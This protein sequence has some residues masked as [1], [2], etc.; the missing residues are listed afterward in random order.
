ML[1]VEVEYLMGRIMAS[2]YNDRSRPEYPPHPSRLFSAM[3]A[4]YEDCDMGNDAKRALEWLE[5][6]P[7]PGILAEIP[8]RSSGGR[9]SVTFYVPVNDSLNAK[10]K[11]DL[12]SYKKQPQI[13]SGIDLKRLRAERNFPAFTPRSSYVKFIWDVG[14]ECDLYLPSLRKIAENVTYLGHSASPVNVRVFTGEEEPNIVPDSDG[15]FSIRTIGRGRLAHLEQVYNLR[16]QN[17]G[18]QPRTGRV[19]RYGVKR[20]IEKIEVEKGNFGSVITFR[21]L[22]PDFIPGE[23]FYKVIEAARGAALHLYPDPIPE[24]VSGHNPDGAPSQT[25]HMVVMPHLDVAHRY[26]SGH[27]LGFSYVFPE[28]TEEGVLD[29]FQE[30]V[31]NLEVLTIGK[32]GVF[33][34]ARITPDML[35]NSPAGIDVKYYKG[36]GYSWATVTPIVLGKHPR[37][38]MVGPGRN[39]GKVFQEACRMSGLPDPE[40]VITMQSSV[41]EGIGL[42]RDFTVPQKFS[43]LLRTN[44]IIRFSER[45]EGPVIIGTGRY[46][47]FGLMR[48]FHGGMN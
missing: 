24:V 23:A 37:V 7:D 15:R 30:S 47:G 6:L 17:P 12:T 25:P 22:S 39:G 10:S 26:A 28:T 38:S 27:I 36:P 20:K 41:F 48:P 34:V 21:M 9:D 33:P 46:S 19:I 45:V 11:S 5:A 42:A 1:I 14:S 35:P 8:D 44:A 16:K 31:S 18:I 40:E 32:L 4:A 13:S 29:H 43:K 3:V 2:S